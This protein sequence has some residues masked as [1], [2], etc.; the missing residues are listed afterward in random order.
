MIAEIILTHQE[1]R[2]KPFTCF[3]CPW[4]QSSHPFIF[5]SHTG[6]PDE[7]FHFSPQRGVSATRSADRE[8]RPFARLPRGFCDGV[9]TK[10]WGRPS[11]V[12]LRA[13]LRCARV[14]SMPRVR[15]RAT[16]NARGR[17]VRM[18]LSLTHT[19]SGC[20]LPPQARTSLR[21]PAGL[22]RRLA[23]A[24]ARPRA[25]AAGLPEAGRGQR[26][27][28]AGLHREEHVL[29]SHPVVVDYLFSHSTRP[30]KP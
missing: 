25:R 23:R 12:A 28:A 27:R 6:N 13:E 21:L 20:A 4:G 30:G 15:A 8:L 19:P 9:Q 22:C 2:A 10:Q 24:S 7:P 17:L 16:P 3:T 11:K 29:L 14:T 5:V 18:H 1:R 26:A